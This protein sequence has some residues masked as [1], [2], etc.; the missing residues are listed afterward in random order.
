MKFSVKIEA[1]AY[2]DIQQ[3]I[4]WYNQQAEK[5]GYK[6]YKELKKTID[7]LK[8]TPFLQVRYDNVRC[9]PLK[10][11]PYMIHFTVHE[12]EKVA[13]IRAVLNTARNPACWKDRAS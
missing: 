13:I 9:L 5:L 4:D 8:T 2:Q 12:A 10:K 1:E 6:F 3:G 11:F 7:Q